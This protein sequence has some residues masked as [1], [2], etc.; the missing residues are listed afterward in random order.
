[1]ADLAKLLGLEVLL[2]ARAGLGTINHTLL[3]A[4][5]LAKR[6]VPV[7]GIVFNGD[8]DPATERFVEDHSGIATIAR[9]PQLD[10]IDPR[11]VRLLADRF[12]ERLSE[13]V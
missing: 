7:A 4:G 2:V 5:A 8:S 10:R 1:M 9:V 6:G 3:T 11:A 12:K 13:L